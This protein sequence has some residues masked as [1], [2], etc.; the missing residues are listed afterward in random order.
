M[1][2]LRNQILFTS[3]TISTGESVSLTHVPTGITIKRIVNPYRLPVLVDMLTELVETLDKVLR[4][5]LLQVELEQILR[6]QAQEEMKEVEQLFNDHSFNP[7]KETRGH[8]ETREGV[9]F[10]TAFCPVRE[11]TQSKPKIRGDG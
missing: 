1:F 6:K 3:R 7:V 10:Q 8:I 4:S 5:R 2:K 9:Q 11:G